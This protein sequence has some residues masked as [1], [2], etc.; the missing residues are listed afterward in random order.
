MSPL[1]RG[2]AAATLLV[3]VA[4]CAD[5]PEPSGGAD[6]APAPSTDAGAGTP[7]ELV[8]SCGR[9]QFDTIPANPSSFPPLGDDAWDEIDLAGLG[10]EADFFEEHDWSVATET[11]QTLHLIGVPQEA[12]GPSYAYA[13]FVREG[14]RWT[15]ENWGGCRVTV[16]AP[17]WGNAHFVLDPE[18]DPDP[19]GASVSV[20][21]WEVDCANGEPPEG[22]EVRPVILS[23]DSDA[24]S[25]VVLV[26]PVTGGA[27]CQSNPSF[28]LEITLAEPLGDRTVYD[29][30]TDPALVRPWP[31]SESSLSSEG[32]EE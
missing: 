31:P 22:R 11:D 21:A 30:S 1:A 20:L 25:I 2:F 14:D 32:R 23:E 12:A 9:I 28:P 18:T 15:P 27:N 6:P 5:T 17:G 26:E 7:D 10:A 29:A 16:A 8:A 19:A 4:G 13:T 3:L 24:V